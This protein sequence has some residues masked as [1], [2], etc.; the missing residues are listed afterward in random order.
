MSAVTFIG[1]ADV[2]LEADVLGN[3]EDPTILLVHGAG[4]TRQVWKEVAEALVDAGRHVIALDLR[5]RG[6]IEWPADGRY[7][8]DAHAENLRAV[9]AQLGGRPVVVAATLGG[10]VATAALAR[11]ATL[12]GAGLVL[13][14]MPA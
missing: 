3:A 7:D 2:R 5:G 13:V 12:L 1:F 10:W 14:D 9:L 4:Q 11:D 6:T 8:L